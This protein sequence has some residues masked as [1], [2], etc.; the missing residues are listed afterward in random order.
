[1][2]FVKG[3]IPESLFF[4]GNKYLIQ[5]WVDIPYYLLKS[6]YEMDYNIYESVVNRFPNYISKRKMAFDT[7]RELPND[8]WLRPRL[9]AERTYYFC[10]NI[11]EYAGLASSEWHVEY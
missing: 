5:K 8:Y 6:I 3:K 9:N 10:N 4:K 2:V 1:M 7:A 11:I